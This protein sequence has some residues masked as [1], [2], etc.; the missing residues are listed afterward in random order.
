MDTF[1]GILKLYSNEPYGTTVWLQAPL[2]LKMLLGPVAADA[3]NA[4]TETSCGACLTESSLFIE[5]RRY[6]LANLLS[7]FAFNFQS[8]ATF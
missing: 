5:L 1:M 3:N 8:R 4:P 6:S 2:V 7:L